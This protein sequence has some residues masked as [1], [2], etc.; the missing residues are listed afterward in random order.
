MRAVKRSLTALRVLLRRSP[1]SALLLVVM[2]LILALIL[3]PGVTTGRVAAQDE[4]IDLRLKQLL[5]RIKTHSDRFAA[6]FSNALDRAPLDGGMRKDDAMALLD[7]FE[8]ETDQLFRRIADDQVV[9]LDVEAMLVRATTIENFLARA[10]LNRTV[11]TDWANV[12]W[13]LIQLAKRY[14][15][16]WTWDPQPGS[17]LRTLPLRQILHRIEMRNDDFLCSLDEA[18]DRRPPASV[19][20]RSRAATLIRDF[21]RSA[22]RMRAL[23]APGSTAPSAE[24]EALLKSAL[25]IERFM[26]SNALTARAQRDWSRVKVHLDDCARASNITWGWAMKTARPSSTAV[27]SSRAADLMTDVVL[28][29]TTSERPELI[30]RRV[31]LLNVRIESIAN[32]RAFWIG[33]NLEQQL[34]VIVDHGQIPEMNIGSRVTIDGTFRR[35]PSPDQAQQLWGLSAAMTK[36]ANQD[37]VYLLADRVA[38][39]K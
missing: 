32:E 38:Q 22:A 39:A 12:R 27:A 30:G 1:V 33:P 8:S 5:S 18:L 7:E 31:R 17:H 15:L 21:E 10:P 2:A 29:E 19:E 4:G 11:Q 9:P 23:L 14:G 20:I 16:S 35:M 28:I 24:T 37:L 13:A 6:S 3:A 36:A 26:R 25:E 34:L